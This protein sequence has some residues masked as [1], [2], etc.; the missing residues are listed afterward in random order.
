MTGI[1]SF[2]CSALFSLTVASVVTRG[3][4]VG[5][6][7]RSERWMDDVMRAIL[8]SDWRKIPAEGVVPDLEVLVWKTGTETKGGLLMKCAICCSGAFLILILPLYICHL[9]ASQ[10]CGFALSNLCVMDFKTALLQVVPFSNAVNIVE[11]SARSL[12]F[13][14]A[15]WLLLQWLMD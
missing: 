1:G 12:M 9:W 11:W 6:I 15:V 3:D 13:L 4:L 2:T 7:L 8:A 5:S 10:R 14:S